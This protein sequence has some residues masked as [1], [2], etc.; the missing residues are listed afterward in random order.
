MNNSDKD[1]N[2]YD[3]NHVSENVEDDG[4][5]LQ[6]ENHASENGEDDDEHLQGENQDEENC[7]D[8]NNENANLVVPYMPTTIISRGDQDYLL[9]KDNFIQ[10][11]KNLA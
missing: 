7:E 4:E 2:E 9:L 10:F 5:H 1:Q 8:S 11:L 6:G 3:E